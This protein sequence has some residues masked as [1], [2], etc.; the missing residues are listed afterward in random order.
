MIQK[1]V[2]VNFREQQV[3]GADADN[4][5]VKDKVVWGAGPIGR[6]INRTPRQAFHLLKSGSIKSAVKKGGRWAAYR[7]ELRR[8]F[9][10][11]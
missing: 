10:G 8:E 1:R 6:E 9:S 11:R 4:G 7:S 2:T 3:M 5:Q